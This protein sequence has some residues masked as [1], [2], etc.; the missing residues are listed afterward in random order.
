MDALTK[1]ETNKIE[2]IFSLNK[3]L[4]MKFVDET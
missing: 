4:I 2:F 1:Y 3:N